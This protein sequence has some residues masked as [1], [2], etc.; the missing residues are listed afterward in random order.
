MADAPIP[1]GRTA[2]RFIRSQVRP[3]PSPSQEGAQ[4]DR[5]LAKRH[6]FKPPEPP[7]GT[8]P[9]LWCR[10]HHCLMRITH[11]PFRRLYCPYCLPVPDAGRKSART[12][13][14]CGRRGCFLMAHYDLWGV[15]V[16][17]EKCVAKIGDGAGV[18]ERGFVLRV[19]A[20]SRGKGWVVVAFYPTSWHTTGN[21]VI[22]LHWWAS[23]RKFPGST[24]LRMPSLLMLKGRHWDRTGSTVG[25]AQTVLDDEV[26]ASF[27]LRLGKSDQAFP[28]PELRAAICEWRM[29]KGPRP[30]IDTTL[31]PAIR[32][33]ESVLARFPNLRRQRPVALRRAGIYRTAV[34]PPEETKQRRVRRAVV[35]TQRGRKVWK[36]LECDTQRRGLP[37]PEEP[38]RLPPD[39]G[40]YGPERQ[41]GGDDESPPE[42]KTHAG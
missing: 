25:A 11:A 32:H 33:A 38:E 12:G 24:F 6:G 35:A 8:D 39:R 29:G 41:L 37:L 23:R 4:A 5:A 20:I 34:K 16:C 2:A 1:D 17:S 22:R 21:V 31:E 27:L 40:L 30:W 18:R 14:R 10:I 3:P 19:V 13:L 42:P 15:P 7:P 36:A 26:V 9:R 28:Q